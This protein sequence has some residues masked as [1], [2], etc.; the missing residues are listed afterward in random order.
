LGTFGRLL[1][2]V[3]FVAVAAVLGFAPPHPEATALT[4]RRAAT[5]ARRRVGT[6]ETPTRMCGVFFL[7]APFTVPATALERALVPAQPHTER[8]PASALTSAYTVRWIRGSARFMMRDPGELS[9]AQRQG[10][11][12]IARRSELL[13]LAH[14]VT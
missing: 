11:R 14:A 2:V 12:V 4:E 7:V 3:P 1:I 5:Y 6:Y 9:A 8:P 10:L 13:A